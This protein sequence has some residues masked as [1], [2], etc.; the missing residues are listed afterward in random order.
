MQRNAKAPT[1]MLWRATLA[2]AVPRLRARSSPLESRACAL[3]RFGEAISLVAV[4]AKRLVPRCWRRA[5]WPE[6]G[7]SQH[8]PARRRAIRLDA[9]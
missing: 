8:L 3:E 6:R 1:R 4:E 7:I 9:L 5:R 2:I